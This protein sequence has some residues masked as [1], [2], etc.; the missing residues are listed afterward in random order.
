MYKKKAV[1]RRM[2]T[3]AIKKI[4]KQKKGVSYARVISNKN[5]YVGYKLRKGN[6]KPYLNIK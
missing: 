5:F 3:L 1:K 2:I 6:W 4:A